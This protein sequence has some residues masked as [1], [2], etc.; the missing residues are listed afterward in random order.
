M[1]VGKPEK[2]LEIPEQT[3]WEEPLTVPPEWEPVPQREPD[4]VETP[5]QVPEKTPA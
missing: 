4:P 1:E 3:P 5:E 2:E